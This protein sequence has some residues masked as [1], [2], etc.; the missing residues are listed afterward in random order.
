MTENLTV[1]IFAYWHDKGWKGFVGATVKIWD[2]AH[3][4]S[5]LGHDVVL[6][7]PKYD[8]SIKNPPFRLVQIPFLDF[9]FLRSLSFSFFLTIFLCRHHFLPERDVFYIRRG[10]S[11]VPAIFAILKKEVLMYEVNDD[12]YENNGIHP[13]GMVSRFEK[14]LAVKTDE[15]VL[16]WCD[17]A[18]V[19]TEQIKDK[20]IR[21]LPRISPAKIHIVASG[22]NTGLYRPMDKYQCRSMLKLDPSM[23]Y[24]GFMGTL[25]EHQGVDIL[26]DAA[27]SVL[28]SV[29]EACFAIIGEGPM[30]KLWQQRVDEP[31]LHGHFLFTGQ[32]EYEQTPLWINAMDVCTAPF[33]ISAGLRSPV[34]IFDYMACSR[35]VVASKIPG[36]T[37]IFDGSGAVRLIEPEDNEALA[38]AIVNVLTGEEEEKEMGA[39]GRRLAE[40]QY[41]RK[42]L[43]KKLEETAYAVRGNGLKT[44][45][46]HLIDS[47]EIAGG[48]RYLLDLIKHSDPAFEH[49]VVL[50]YEGPFSG[51][52]RDHQIRYV[53]ISMKSTFSIKSICKIRDFILNEKIDIVHTHGYRCNL[54]GRLACLS[55]GISNLATVHVSLYDYVDTP[56]W[57]RRAY[58]LIEKATSPLAS[59]YICI[60]DAM[61]D[62]LRALGI[63]DEKLIV[64]QNGVDL[65]VFYPR[66]AFANLYDEMRIGS[67]RP[68]IG[69]AGRMVT[70]KGQIHL[71]EALPYL[72]DRW[73]KL[74]CLL[75]GTGPLM[76]DFKKRVAAL[77]L[78]ETC[79]FPG[80]RMDMPDV[81]PLL[82]LFVLPSLREPFGLVLLEAMASNIPVIAT[83]A[84]GP[85]DFIRSGVNGILVPPSDPVKLAEQID[86]MLSN[87]DRLMALAKRG[88]ETVKRGFDVRKTVRTIEETYRSLI[89]KKRHI[90]KTNDFVSR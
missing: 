31:S 26:I 63:R 29:P 60:S 35:P 61:R 44:R 41:D 88:Y 28:R 53:L 64:I 33:L 52:L 68:V 32:I 47:S 67:H 49:I 84:G 46:L 37:D 75:I 34:K 83:A 69:T 72:L 89:G 38:S 8:Y 73:P 5:L 40:T 39:K 86:M 45:V 1:L 4:M 30:K 82:D 81:Y 48:E 27:P 76:D 56:S 55:T 79:I 43:A 21:Q 59:S 3:N 80:V 10:I 24:I 16:S 57:L 74:R 62:D 6:F 65:E 78:S 50:S 36:T 19:I 11:I 70:E 77:G 51:Q 58:L 23:K 42:F 71:I 20:I 66:G 25:L 87:P 2:L 85:M 18:F 15:I 9:P 54:Y 90:T 12:P 22:T 7:L 17:A 13:V 14:W